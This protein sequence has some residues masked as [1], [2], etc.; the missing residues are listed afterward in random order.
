MHSKARR[1]LTI[2][3]VALTLF[4]CGQDR[5][6]TPTAATETATAKISAASEG[7]GSVSAQTAVPKVTICHV[8]PGNP[9]NAH[10]ITIGAPAVPHHLS[11]HPGDHIGPCSTPTPSPTPTPAD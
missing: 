11:N 10:T 3:A 6:S 5:P 8:P 1:F 4:A 7:E 2:G 9:A